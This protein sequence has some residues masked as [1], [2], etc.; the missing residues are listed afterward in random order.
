M[1]DILKTAP[2]TRVTTLADQVDSNIVPERLIVTSSELFGVLGAALAGIGIYGLLA[3]TVARRT[4]E[5]CIRMALGATPTDVSSLVL[6]DVVGMVCGR[7]ISGVSLVFSGRPLA[8]SLVHDLKPNS[9]GALV[10]GGFVIIAV[11][12]VASYVPARRAVRVD[13]MMALRHD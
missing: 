13:P 12:L 11:R 10:F 9:T 8:V 6:R 1:R 2:V 7:V 4:N 3:Y 5:V